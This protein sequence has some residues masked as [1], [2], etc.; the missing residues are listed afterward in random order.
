MSTIRFRAGETSWAQGAFRR[1]SQRPRH[2]VANM[3]QGKVAMARLSENKGLK[4]HGLRQRIEQRGKP[5]LVGKHSILMSGHANVFN[6]NSTISI[7]LPEADIHQP[8]RG[9]RRLFGELS[10]TEIYKIINKMTFYAEAQPTNPD[11]VGIL[12]RVR[13]SGLPFYISVNASGYTIFFPQISSSNTFSLLAATVPE[14][15]RQHIKAPIYISNQV[16]ENESLKDQAAFILQN[17][18]LLYKALSS[19]RAKAIKVFHLLVRVEK[20]HASSGITIIWIDDFE[21][22]SDVGIHIP[23]DEADVF[24]LG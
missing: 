10:A 8:Y 20:Y 5:I 15:Y 18:S 9:S 24:Q 17:I 12:E 16:L 2:V 22:Y 4:L 1:N 6:D 3:G 7:T 19:E 23:L 11:Q 21:N 14:V 13:A